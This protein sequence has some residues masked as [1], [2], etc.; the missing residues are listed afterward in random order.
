MKKLGIDIGAGNVRIALVDGANIKVL[1]KD[2]AGKPIERTR[3]ILEE[4]CDS[5]NYKIGVTGANRKAI[6]ELLEIK[7]VL[8]PV[9]ILNYVE[10]HLPY[11]RT[12]FDIGKEN[13]RCYVFEKD[14]GNFSLADF[15]LNLSCGAGGGTLIEKMAKRLQFENLDE[16]V[17]SADKAE[18]IANISARCT[19]FAESDVV[20]HFQRGSDVR[21]IAAGLCQVVSRNFANTICKDMDL[22]E[23]IYMIGG[24]AQ[25]KAIVRFIEEEIRKDIIIPNNFADIKAIGAAL[26][27]DEIIKKDDMINKLFSYKLR[28]YSNIGILSLED[29]IINSLPYEVITENNGNK[30]TLSLNKN[31]DVS[32]G[33]IGAYLGLDVG[34]VSTKAALIDEK[35]EF[36]LGVYGR[37]SGKPIDAVKDVVR[38]MGDIEIKGRQI[39][40]FVD[41][42]MAGTTGSGRNVA[43]KIIGADIVKN[44]ITAQARGAAYFFP[45]VDTVF[46]I[47]GQD[48]KYIF[49]NSGVVVDNEMNK[50]C[51]ASTGSFL[52]EQAKGL[53]IKI[54]KEFAN[55][56]L[57]SKE[58]LDLGDR[59]TVFITNSLLTFQDSPLED[60]CAGLA[61]S[62][63]NN[64]LNRVV[65]G[66]EVGEKIV[67]QGAVAFN[68]AVVAGF[69]TL[70]GKGIH[71]PKYPHLT[72]AIGIA[73]IAKERYNE[74]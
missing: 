73:D 10:N 62:I 9:A 21:G 63:T 44:E 12:I 46:E 15:S 19:V 25:N 6:S 16:F 26:A 2:S 17:E 22:V 74:F 28:R 34:S 35:G 13:S 38:K 39:K 64:Y 70:L 72:G 33:R 32:R 61:Y 3:E 50:A 51:A 41:V 14:N 56:A 60:K 23:P 37:T 58:P 4:L 47:G 49:M 65:R 55:L 20:H 54:E 31:Y 68:K 30:V 18:N 57:D 24:V 71:I 1:A 67:F 5:E 36:I 8:D 40:N 48:S 69:E 27:S 29:S 45:D 59:C 7:S 43:G 53:N 66:K 42:L 52:E 11:A